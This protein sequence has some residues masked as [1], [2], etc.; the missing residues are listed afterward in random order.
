MNKSMT[1]YLGTYQLPAN[2]K[3][4]LIWQ[5]NRLICDPLTSSAQLKNW[6]LKNAIN[7]L[8]NFLFFGFIN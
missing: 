2:P 7:P 3:I 1:L 5:L 8:C 4:G 6:F